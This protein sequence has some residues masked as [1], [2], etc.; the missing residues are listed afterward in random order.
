MPAGRKPIYRPE[1]LKIGGRIRL[2][3]KNKEFGHQYAYSFREKTGWNFKRVE[4]NG[5]IF[6]ERT[7]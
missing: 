1:T 3:G 4:E 2:R 6:I 5:K 7:E